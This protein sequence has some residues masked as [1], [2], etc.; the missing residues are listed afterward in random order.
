[1]DIFIVKD[2]N[3]PKI[4]NDY[5]EVF[6]LLGN[7]NDFIRSK[8]TK[9]KDYVFFSNY[10]VTPDKYGSLCVELKESSFR[11]RGRYID[12]EEFLEAGRQFRWCSKLTNISD[13]IHTD[14]FVIYD[15][16]TFDFFKN[17]RLVFVQ[18]PPSLGDDSYLT[19]PLL[20]PNYR[21]LVARQ[22][23]NDMIFDQD[24][25]LKYLLEHL[26]RS[27]YRISKFITIVRF[28]DTNELNLTRLCYNR[29]KFK[30]FVFAW[31][32]GIP[33]NEKVLDTYKKVSDLI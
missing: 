23:T 3:Y 6:I 30:A 33:E 16:Y 7:H 28:K 2:N 31:F 10:L 24:S 18:V 22:T 29:N 26:I 15:I 4:D 19:N 14:K 13:D 20:S 11:H 8:L 1:M 12:V 21:N 5:H 32:N 25:F 27:H 9:L 17:K